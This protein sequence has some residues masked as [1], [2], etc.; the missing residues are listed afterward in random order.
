[1]SGSVPRCRTI[2][3]S[4]FRGNRSQAFMQRFLRDLDDE[5]KGAGPGPSRESCLLYAGHTGVS[6]DE[7]TA[8]WGFNPDR[9][10]GL[11]VW[12][13]IN[14]LKKGVAFQGTVVD[15]TAVF[16][17]AKRQKMVLVSFDV[18]FPD[19]GFQ[20]FHT[21]L[22]QE[23]QRS[24]YLY[25]FPDGDGDCNC[26]TWLER[27]GLPLLTGRMDEFVALLGIAA[28]PSRRFGRCS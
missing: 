14:D 12:Q 3:V 7:D 26:T 23:R 8:I 6:T 25:G 20:S 15:D 10:R 24:Q 22:D 28:Y 13:M 17:E 2:H 19:P 21:R 11:S 27:L 5:R 18:I 1:M 16:T 9:P 4:A